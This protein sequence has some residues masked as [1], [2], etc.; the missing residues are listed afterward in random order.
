MNYC[1]NIA[2]KKINKQSWPELTNL[3]HDQETKQTTLGIEKGAEI[4]AKA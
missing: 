4:Q 3:G 1:I 2:V